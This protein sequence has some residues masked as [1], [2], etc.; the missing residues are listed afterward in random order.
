[1]STASTPVISFP[2]EVEFKI[3][4]KAIEQEEYE[5]LT[6]TGNVPENHSDFI[7]ELR[8][9]LAEDFGLEL[10]EVNGVKLSK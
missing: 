10:T 4:I 3:K 6:H 1:M 7:V 2:T 8:R 9:V 5:F